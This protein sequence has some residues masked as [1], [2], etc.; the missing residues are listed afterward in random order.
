M[1]RLEILAER[2]RT[3]GRKFEQHLQRCEGEV[4]SWR[5]AS[6]DLYDLRPYEY[7]RSG[8][9]RGRWLKSPPDLS[10]PRAAPSHYGLNAEGEPVVERRYFW[11]SNGLYERLLFLREPDHWEELHFE[12]AKKWP[13]LTNICRVDRHERRPVLASWYANHQKGFEE[14]TYAGDQLVRVDATWSNQPFGPRRLLI[15]H[16]DLTYD[17]A[18]KL[19]SITL[20]YEKTEGHPGGTFPCYPGRGK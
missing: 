5:W 20:T 2:F 14:Y 13:V 9:T 12:G 1:E 15:A 10:K 11:G 3:T 4:E 17:E 7:E 16:W 18:G 6:R 19:A 8:H